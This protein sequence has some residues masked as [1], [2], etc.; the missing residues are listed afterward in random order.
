[1]YNSTYVGPDGIRRTMPISS[2]L[3]VE[4]P[5]EDYV[6]LKTKE[7]WMNQYKLLNNLHFARGR[8]VLNR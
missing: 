2:I 8:N 7:T 6:N 1:M 5:N 3:Q 4:R